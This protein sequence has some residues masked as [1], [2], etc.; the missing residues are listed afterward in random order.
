MDSN[1]LAADLLG[2]AEFVRLAKLE[3][4]AKNLIGTY[5][6]DRSVRWLQE[7][8]KAVRDGEA[9]TTGY[10]DAVSEGSRVVPWEEPTYDFTPESIQ[11]V[12]EAIS[13]HQHVPDCKPHVT[14][15]I[16]AD[17]LSGVPKKFKV[18]TID[19]PDQ[20]KWPRLEGDYAL[21]S[22]LHI[23]FYDPL[24][25]E[26]LMTD[27]DKAGVRRLV[28][29]GDTFDLNSMNHKRGS[30]YQRKAQDDVEAAR[31]VLKAL[32]ECFEEIQVFSG[33]HDDWIAQAMRDHFSTS[34]L[35]SS[36]FKEMPK[37]KW[38]KYGQAD[39][40]SGGKKWKLLHGTSFSGANPLGPA[41]RYASQFQC[42]I[43]SGHQ[44]RCEDGWDVS[45]NFRCVVLGGAYDPTRMSYLHRQPSPCGL[46]KRSFGILRDG[47]LHHVMDV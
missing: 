40:M 44:H 34:F 2:N 39:V 25:L 26:R 19:L 29:C 35:F 31:P 9:E 15:P 38:S 22:D 20:T 13:D 37:I 28:I 12:A 16:W 32:L 27:S 47:Y 42:N 41:K 21:V 7:V 14:V 3:V 36:F 5:A 23:P 18:P 45:G 8:C 11:R 6:P 1:T 43:V 4:P 17:A 30:N 24:V 33:N 46:P 10:Y